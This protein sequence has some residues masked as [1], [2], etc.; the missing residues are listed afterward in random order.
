MER[1]SEL[2]LKLKSIV[3]I[4][5][6]NVRFE[7]IWPTVYLLYAGDKDVQTR[8]TC[9]KHHFR[10]LHSSSQASSLNLLPRAPPPPIPFP[11]GLCWE[12]SV[13]LYVKY[14][15]VKYIRKIED[16]D[17]LKFA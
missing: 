4:Y 2:N 10:A 1:W 9:R 13:C 14:F 12:F 15:L 5:I 17:I 16:L 11:H 8:Q 3:K 6:Q 7:K